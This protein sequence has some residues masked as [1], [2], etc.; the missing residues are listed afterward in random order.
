MA[1]T[2]RQFLKFLVAV[3]AFIAGFFFPFNRNA[4][5]KIGEMKTGT[6]GVPEA[7]A[8]GASSHDD[9]KQE[10][11]AKEYYYYDDGTKFDPDLIPQ[12]NLCIVCKHVD[13][14][15]SQGIICRITRADQ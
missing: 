6:I 3:S 14:D 12:P 15:S 4:G 2:R 5:F 1:K 13:D 9:E 10:G 8:K 7:H 11:F